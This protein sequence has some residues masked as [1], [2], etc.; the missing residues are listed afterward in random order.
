M[1]DWK[2]KW[3]A[4][5]HELDLN[6]K[7]KWE[8]FWLELVT[9]MEEF[10]VGVKDFWFWFWWRLIKGLRGI[11]MHFENFKTE[12]FLIRTV[13]VITKSGESLIEFG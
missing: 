9:R 1:E 11:V 13:T 10:D 12:V 5:V 2:K 3:K 8:I 7:T 6:L 4:G